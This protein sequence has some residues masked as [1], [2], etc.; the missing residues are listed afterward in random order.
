MYY[1]NWVVFILRKMIIVSKD[2]VLNFL[3]TNKNIFCKKK[4]RYL[5]S[6]MIYHFNVKFICNLLFTAH[7]RLSPAILFSE[8]NIKIK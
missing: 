8:N 4:I 5:P 2:L 3:N 1:K 6:K 7:Y